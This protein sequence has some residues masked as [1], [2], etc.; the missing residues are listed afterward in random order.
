MVES[1]RYS[2]IAF[3][4]DGLDALLLLGVGEP[5]P[6]PLASR[7]STGGSL[8]QVEWQTN[9][10][11]VSAAIPL[12]DFHLLDGEGIA[13]IAWVPTGGNAGLVYVGN[14][15]NNTVFIYSL[16]GRG[17]NQTLVQQAN[18]SP[19]K[20]GQGLA[21]LTKSADG[22]M[23][24]A[25]YNEPPSLVS[26]QLGNDGMPQE[27]TVEVQVGFDLS[28]I[29]GVTWYN[30]Q[31]QVLV[32]SRKSGVVALYGFGDDGPSHNCVERNME[33]YD[34]AAAVNAAFGA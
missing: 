18:F 29:S 23:M 34:P 13:G 4:G 10:A 5:T 12:P 8:L 1:Q 25:V 33:M 24:S 22:T 19:L 16:E 15:V 7:L 20:G 31:R 28:P 32:S 14:S 17:T 11:V 27:D 3:A 21:G 9:K 6:S 30:D 26:F 2:G